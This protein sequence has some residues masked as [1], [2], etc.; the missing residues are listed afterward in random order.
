[1]VVWEQR[2]EATTN[3]F[4]TDRNSPKHFRGGKNKR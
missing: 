4:G 3:R 2:L 1:M